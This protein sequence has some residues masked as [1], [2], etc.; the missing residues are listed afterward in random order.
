M[1]DGR[2]LRAIRATCASFMLIALTSALGS[3]S[4]QQ[5]QPAPS[6]ERC[7]S[8]VAAA[9]VDSIAAGLFVSIARIDGG[10]LTQV[11]SDDILEAIGE[12]FIPPRPLRLTI[13]TGPI[14]TR[15]LRSLA[16]DTVPQLSAPT[17]TGVY[18]FSARK[19]GTI[20]RMQIVRESL[21]RGFDSAGTA[22]IQA[23]AQLHRLVPPVGEDSMR[24]E[25]RFSTDSGSGARRIV[26]ATFPR[27]PVVNAMPLRDNPPP[28]FPDDEKGD[29]TTT[30]E[31]VFRFVVDRTGAPMMETV[32][33]LR[34]RSLSFIKAALD[35]LPKQMF[36]PAT[37]RGC[38]VSQRVDYPFNFAAPSSAIGGVLRH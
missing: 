4:G 1:S 14:R 16:T 17:I 11:Q 2:S 23:I 8:I 30:G 27:M 38:P 22:A 3:A 13:F 18:R 9:R 7:D 34:G 31:V 20:A 10:D 28:V 33:L 12:T 25:I 5:P 36:A 15:I 21:V 26:A 32:E 29:S 37:I 19:R 24:A 35:I 6:V